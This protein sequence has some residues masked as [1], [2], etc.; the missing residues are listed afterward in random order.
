MRG[1]QIQVQ[2]NM[3]VLVFWFD[4]ADNLLPSMHLLPPNSATFLQAQESNEALHQD[5]F[6]STCCHSCRFQIL[7]RAGCKPSIRHDPA[8][9][10][11]ASLLDPMLMPPIVQQ[12]NHHNRLA[13]T[14]SAQAGDLISDRLQKGSADAFGAE[15]SSR[16]RMQAHLAAYLLH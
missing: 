6:C 3:Y 7:P 12:R 5:S 13:A 11:S 10:G 9:H 4:F 8:A 1:W 16:E 2:V 14:P 15:T